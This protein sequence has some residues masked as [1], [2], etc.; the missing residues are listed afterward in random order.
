M[1]VQIPD[2]TPC[3]HSL[4][5]GLK[6][7]LDCR[8]VLHNVIK[9]RNI[10]NYLLLLY[11]EVQGKQSNFIQKV[12]YQGSTRPCLISKPPEHSDEHPGM[13]DYRIPERWDICKHFWSYETVFCKQIKIVCKYDKDCR[14]ISYLAVI[15]Q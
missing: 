6:L 8:P 10:N 11:R 12:L 5:F 13:L 9:F 2:R 14:Q 4:F 3:P 1:Y 7:M 15:L